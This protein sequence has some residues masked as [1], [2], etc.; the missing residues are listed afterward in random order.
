MQSFSHPFRLNAN[1]Q[2]ATVTQGTDS[3]AA[4]LIAALILTRYGEKE[5]VPTFGTS[6]PIMVGVNPTE[7]A[8]QVAAFGPPVR[9][10]NIIETQSTID[11][12]AVQIE[13]N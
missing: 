4:Q 13:F 8:A 2:V 10:V 9:I 5:M 12:A 3:W 11:S 7:V 1:G 6:D